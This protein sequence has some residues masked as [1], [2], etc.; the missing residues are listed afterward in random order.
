MSEG[1]VKNM[2]GM[3]EDMPERSSERMSEKGCQKECSKICQ[4]ECQPEVGRTWSSGGHN[5]YDVWVATFT[6]ASVVCCAFVEKLYMCLQLL[7]GKELSCHVQSSKIVS[8]IQFFFSSCHARSR[9]GRSSK[10]LVVGQLFSGC[11]RTGEMQKAGCLPNA[12]TEQTPKHK[13]KP[14]TT[15]RKTS[16]K[17]SETLRFQNDEILGALSTYSRR[18]SD[19]RK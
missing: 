14:N 12:E 6:I 8:E 4:Q 1:M 15:R 19:S 7:L 13:H 3:S 2:S 18:H 16:S 10:R 11:K 17:L 9:L 5:K